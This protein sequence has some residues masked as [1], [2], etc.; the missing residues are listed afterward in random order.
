[1]RRRQRKDVFLAPTPGSS[2]PRLKMYQVLGYALGRG[3]RIIE[4]GL[5]SAD[6]FLLES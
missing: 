3:Q 6:L 1:M 5:R 2:H 4:D